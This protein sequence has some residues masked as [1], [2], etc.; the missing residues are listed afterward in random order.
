MKTIS[1]TIK[2]YDNNQ[3]QNYYLYGEDIFLERFFIK[4]LSKKF[5]NQDG[6][7]VLYH[8][9]VDDESLFFT[10]LKSNS[11]F[12]DKKMII[13]W[14]INKLS[15][16]G[17]IELLEYINNNPS[18]DNSLIIISPGFKV[19]NKFISELSSK[20][21]SVDIRT[22]FPS[23]MKNWI[24]FYAK[25]KN[26]TISNELLDFY[27]EYF[28]DDLSSVINEL[29]KHN[30]YMSNKKLDISDDYSSYL[31]S[32]RKFHYWQFLDNI[33]KKQCIKSLN[34][35][36]SLIV[37]GISHNYML[38]GLI[39][40]FINIYS[41]NLYFNVEKEFPVLNKILQRNMKQYTSNYSIAESSSIINHLYKIDK[42][43]KTF[44][45]G[46]NYEFQLL[47]LKACNG[48]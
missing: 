19:K 18:R 13:C 37:N 48:K 46:I 25:T 24:K 9:G 34:I 16:K 12:D 11:L 15:K 20:L 8:F 43:V 31:E 26:I 38:F 4:Q 39:N 47:I 1:E 30:M 22:P 2:N 7:K 27:I 28:G 23:K 40:L 33:G 32:G 29:D 21:T 3:S 10:D 6:N 14:E 44:Q 36:E 35:Y 45:Y 5:I 41:N 17:Q 42:M